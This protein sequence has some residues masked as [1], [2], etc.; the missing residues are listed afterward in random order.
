MKK[1]SKKSNGLKL[2]ILLFII[3]CI[4]GIGYYF[5]H[6]GKSV[7]AWI[8]EKDI[9]IVEHLNKGANYFESKEYSSAEKEFQEAYKLAKFADIE[10]NNYW[11]DRMNKIAPPRKFYSGNPGNRTS[12][13]SIYFKNRMIDAIFGYASSVYWQVTS[14]YA[15]QTLKAMQ[16]QDPNYKIP[17]SEFKPA[18]DAID[19]GI[20]I[21]PKSEMLRILKAEILKDSGKYTEALSLL[22]E[23]VTLINNSS[24]EAY[25]LMGIIYSMPFYMQTDNYKI[26]KEKA[27]AMLEKASMLPSSTGSRLA[28]PNYNLALYYSTPPA[29]KAI[30]SFPS[31][32]DAKKAI[33]YFEEY[34]DIAGENAEFSTKAK[35]EIERLKRIAPQ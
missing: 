2:L 9:P 11:K 28:A 18:L 23:V 24:A 16:N 19:T 29:N 20:N 17:E 1:K 26:Y 22:D 31:P 21:E 25:N 10:S 7:E 32:L 33:Q 13:G 4:L 35:A 14:R 30:N 27:I 34:L 6:F 3:A 12:S 5:S 8:K 15:T